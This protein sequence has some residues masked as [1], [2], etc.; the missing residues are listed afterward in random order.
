MPPSIT[1]TDDERNDLLDH[2]RADPDP[3]LR[4]RAHI[5][6]LLAQGHTW[7]LITAVLFCSSQTVARWQ[8][9]FAD[10]RVA[11]LLG[12]ARGRPRR[13]AA[14]WAALML[15]WV[16]DKAPRAFGLHRSRWSC[17]TVALLLWQ[18]H[19]VRASRETVRRR[20][21]EGDLVWRR[22]RPVIRPQD[23]RR[24]AI[25]TALRRQM[26]QTP[27]DETW[28]FTDEVDVN[29]NPD[30]GPMWMR[31]GQQAEVETPGDNDK[32]YL[33]GSQHWRTGAVLLTVGERREGRT[34]AL[35]VRHLEDLRRR[36][37]RYRRIH[38]LCDNARAHA[39]ALVAAYLK[40]HGDRIVLHYLPKRAPE[41]NPIERVWWHLH[42]EITR[43]HSCQTM[44]ELLELVLAWLGERNP[45]PVEGSV[46]PRPQ[47]A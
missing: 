12:Q 43:N 30:L 42:D 15:A 14:R 22:P 19:R 17:A 44:P 20:L 40:E 6:L 3:A 1:L 47:A 16:L 26:A 32:R 36:L 46:Y 45:F 11:G 25:L 10:G 35:F 5:I 13:L 31:K 29:L 4:L 7:A 39:C 38:V 2:Y 41:C 24:E 9:R 27:E 34:A 21:R 18:E 28:V 33:A 8:R 37:R 23:P